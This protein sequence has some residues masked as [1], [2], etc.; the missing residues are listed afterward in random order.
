M[1]LSKTYT[2]DELKAVVVAHGAW[3]AGDPKGARADLSG[4]YLSGA[5]DD[6]KTVW[7]AFFTVPEVGAFIAWK[8][9]QGGVIAKLEIPAKAKRTSSLVGRKCR[10]EYVKTIALYNAAG[11]SLK[12]PGPGL[13]DVTVKYAVG[14]ITLPDEYDPDP[15]VECAP[16]IHF[17]I[18]RREAESY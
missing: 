2:A 10:A 1:A 14:K 6:D 13:H 5:K 7:P 17:F 15:K 18:T 11:K 4:A 12:G 8:K 9:L 3:L 16:G